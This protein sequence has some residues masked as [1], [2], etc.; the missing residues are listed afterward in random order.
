M[1]PDANQ[2]GFLLFLG[3]A[4]GAVAG[5]VVLLGAVV[6][7]KWALAL[8]ILGLGAVGVAAYAALLIGL[9]VTSRETVL[10]RGVEKHICEIDCHLAYAVTGVRTA[11]ELRADGAVVPARGRLW[12]VQ[13]RSRFDETTMGP[14]RP[15]NA[16]VYGG[17]RTVVIV[18]ERGHRYAPSDAAR[19][20]LP[21]AGVDC[22]A[23]GHPLL[24]GASCTATL[25]FDLPADVRH[26]RLLVA[27][28]APE[29][30]LVIGHEMS[31]GHRRA[32]FELTP[33]SGMG[34]P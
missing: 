23:E 11:P 12:I 24:P 21:A 28:A 10:G 1:H 9:A 7:R 15:L 29:A 22:L 14:R 2:L 8:T 3:G 32:Y 5:G 16:P 17:P 26:P 33:D 20:A 4:L 34:E 31:P 19:P 25:A 27:N 6:A 30:V 13:V 18:D